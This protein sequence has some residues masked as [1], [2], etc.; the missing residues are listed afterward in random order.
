MLLQLYKSDYD[1][2]VINKVN[3]TQI[4]STYSAITPTKDVDIVRP[5]FILKYISG[6]E[7]CNYI[8]CD[9]LNRYY[10]AQPTLCVGNT[11]RFDCVTDVLMSFDIGN[12]DCVVR[13]TAKY[14]KPTYI[15][16]ELLPFTPNIRPV[17][18]EFPN[19]PHINSDGFT[20]ISVL[21]HTI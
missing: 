18:D 12:I 16:D 7:Q 9:T 15:K 8:K 21:V 13:R 17:I 19:T 1:N 14:K 20:S 5:T 4:G 2:R 3:I 11:I 10:F 6:M